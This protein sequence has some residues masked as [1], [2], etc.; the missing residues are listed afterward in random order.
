MSGVFSNP[1]LWIGIYG[2]LFLFFGVAFI[3]WSYLAWKLIFNWRKL[4]ATGTTVTQLLASATALSTAANALAATATA[5][6]A[7]IA[8]LQSGG[9]ITQPQLDSVNDSLSSSLSSL[10]ASQAA[11][12]ALVPAPPAS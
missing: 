7:L 9:L 11:L 12:A 8:S 6:E 10:Q 4:M 3:V 2:I 1:Y 5:I